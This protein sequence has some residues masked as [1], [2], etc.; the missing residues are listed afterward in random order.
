MIV[1]YHLMTQGSQYP[2]QSIPQ[3]RR[4]DVADV[5]WLGD[6]WRT[7]INHHSFGLGRLFEEKMFTSPGR[8]QGSSQRR[9]FEP[10]IQK[11]CSSGLDLLTPFVYV[12]SCDYVSSDLPWIE[13]SRLGQR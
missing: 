7:E 4:A 10:E 8:L 11:T 3:N 1:G 2:S 6:I 13:F 9:R 12:Q 5:H